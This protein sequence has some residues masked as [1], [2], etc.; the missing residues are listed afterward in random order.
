MSPWAI[1]D[2]APTH[3][4]RE[5]KRAYARLLKANRPDDNP[6]GF[7][8]LHQAYKSALSLAETQPA[9]VATPSL[10]HSEPLELSPEQQA[11]WTVT[12]PPA[13][14]AEPQAPVEE[15]PAPA[16]EAVSEAHMSA[17]LERCRALVAQHHGARQPQYWTFLSLEPL[18]LDTN[19]H[20]QF[21]DALFAILVEHQHQAP[22]N[23]TGLTPVEPEILGYLNSLFFWDTRK[24][25]LAVGKPEAVCNDLFHAIED[26]Q[27]HRSLQ[28]VRGGKK[29]IRVDHEKK[30]NETPDEYLFASPLVRAVATLFELF[31]L[32]LA[33]QAVGELSLFA[34]RF[35]EQARIDIRMALLLPVY[36]LLAAL[37]QL[38]PLQATPVQRALGFRLLTRDLK[39]VTFKPVLLRTLVLSSVPLLI[40]LETLYSDAGLVLAML[41]GANAFLDGKLI[42]DRL[43]GTRLIHYRLS[44]Q[45]YRERTA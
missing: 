1:L 4:I 35:D 3:D 40:Y 17:L 43:S 31:L 37:C 29:L 13:P 26:I 41:L 34:D 33:M 30:R 32:S 42:Q 19:L 24:D 2:M 7:Q 5:I 8:R 39:R 11:A 12:L 28:A 23:T 25:E 20:H 21:G 15:P 36:L 10:Q 45:R 14:V 27:Q 22:W 38:S 16:E 44:L 9:P 6:D 18:L